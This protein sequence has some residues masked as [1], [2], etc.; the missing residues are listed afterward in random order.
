MA[1][2]GEKNLAS[3]HDLA[4]PFF[5]RKYPLPICS[6][7]LFLCPHSQPAAAGSA[8]ILAAVS[9]ILPETLGAWRGF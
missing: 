6:F 8:A 2:R 4:K 7:A 5:S 1:V 3:P 9:G